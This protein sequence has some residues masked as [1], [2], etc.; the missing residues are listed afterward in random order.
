MKVGMNT[1]H[2]LKPHRSGARPWPRSIARRG[3][4]STAPRFMHAGRAEDFLDYPWLDA[5]GEQH[6]LLD[7]GAKSPAHA[8]LSSTN[9]ASCYRDAR[10]LAVCL[11]CGLFERGGSR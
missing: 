6:R 2:I 9:R 11:R 5:A 1:S 7:Q 4:D 3:E 10:K 8:R